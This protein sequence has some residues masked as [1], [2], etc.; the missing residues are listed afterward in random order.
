MRISRLGIARGPCLRVAARRRG[1]PSATGA[2]MPSPSEN[3][4]TSAPS[5]PRSFGGLAGSPRKK[6]PIRFARRMRRTGHATAW[7]RRFVGFHWPVKEPIFPAIAI[8]GRLETALGFQDKSSVPTRRSCP[9]GRPS[10]PPPGFPSLKS[11]T[12]KDLT[13]C[14][15]RSPCA[16]VCAP[17]GAMPPEERRRRVCQCYIN[18]GEHLGPPKCSGLL[19]EF[20]YRAP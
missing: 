13:T 1:R 18:R 8:T 19:Y 2:Q 16:G 10:S 9:I 11:P 17:G 3:I 7:G 20:E 5:A 4:Y 14:G 12:S 15:K 6:T